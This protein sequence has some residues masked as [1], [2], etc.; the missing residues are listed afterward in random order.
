MTAQHARAGTGEITIGRARIGTGHPC[1]IIAEAGVNHDGDIALAHRLVDVAADAGA[2]AVKFQTFDADTLA[3]ADASKAAYQ[4]ETT[5]TSE[6]QRSM[7]KRIQLPRDA[8]RAL[9][10]HAESRGIVFLSSPF[11]EAS[12]EFLANLGVLAFK[13][14]SGELINLPLLRQIARYGRPMIVSTGMATLAEVDAAAREIESEGA[15]YAL[16]HCVSLYPT[17]P[18]HANLRA[19]AT[20][21]SAFSVAVGF[22]DHT[23]G[24]AVSIA[25]AALGAAIIEKHYTVD[26]NRAGPDHRASLEPAELAR[27]IADIRAVG[28]ALGTGRKHPAV[29]E[30]AVAKAA[31]K[32]LVAARDIAAGVAL[33]ELDLVAMRPGT[34]LAPDLLRLVLG[35]RT[36]IPIS[37]GT[38]IELDML[39]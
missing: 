35:R 12:A 37:A 28:A 17:P 3:T 39:A 24:T 33:D 29:E 38:V 13:I 15:P 20:L 25:A 9:K 30:A 5:S 34:G 31:R 22:S 1:F 4:L 23:L 11:D 2:D 6:T 36:R 14:P 10:A 18:E 21:A 32:S 7:L 16:L 8:H 19:M 26:R 27:M